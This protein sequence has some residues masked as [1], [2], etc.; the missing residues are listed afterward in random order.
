MESEKTPLKRAE[1]LIRLLV[2]DWRL[3]QQQ[4]LWVIRIAIVLGVLVAIGY[5]Y[6]IT[7]WDW[8]K[9]LII[10]AANLSDLGEAAAF[11]RQLRDLAVL[12]YHLEAS[13][14]LV[15]SSTSFPDDKEPL[16]TEVP[17]RST[18]NIVWL[19]DHDLLDP[20]FVLHPLRYRR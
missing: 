11:A 17:S 6:G 18:V 4:S 3:T 10:P 14:L 8:A 16:L 2:P 1:D 13:Q 19:D 7:L 9:L 15:T 20:D 5:A 12:A